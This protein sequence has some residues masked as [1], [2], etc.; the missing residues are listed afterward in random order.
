MAKQTKFETMISERIEAE[1]ARIAREV[2]ADF[3]QTV[4]SFDVPLNQFLGEMEN[5]GM[6]AI[7]SMPVAD[8]ARAVS[9]ASRSQPGA[10]FDKETRDKLA[11]ITVPDFIKSKGPATLRAISTAAG[12]EAR[13]IKRLLAD[14]VQDGRL[15]QDGTGASATYSLPQQ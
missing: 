6:G 13:K 5:A 7:M 14:M 10:R 12:F 4:P 11:A 8:L 3:L 15:V 9:K 1:K 2:I